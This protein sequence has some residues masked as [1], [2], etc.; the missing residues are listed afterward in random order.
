MRQS[1]DRI[2]DQ[3]F[4]EAL[5]R[6]DELIA[7]NRA[8][9]E[10][11]G[12]TRRRCFQQ[13]LR[14]SVAEVVRRSRVS[15][16]VCPNDGGV[17]QVGHPPGA[18]TARW[19]SYAF[20]RWGRDS[21]S[22]R[23]GPYGRTPRVRAPA[24]SWLTSQDDRRTGQRFAPKHMAIPNRGGVDG[25]RGPRPAGLCRAAHLYGPRRAP[26]RHRQSEGGAGR[27]R[28]REGFI[29]AVAPGRRLSHRQQPLSEGRGSS[30]MPAPR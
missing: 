7:A 10:A 16:S 15:A 4:R 3:P 1:D 6:P 8:R 20:Q 14:E 11:R 18:F 26:G 23:R 24:R 27:G 25:D 5:P 30:S 28:G 19:W 22:A 12:R 17:R 21:S 29:T 2:L 13:T 9:D